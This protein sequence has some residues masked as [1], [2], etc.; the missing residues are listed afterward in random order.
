MTSSLDE[1]L[2]FS[3]SK[4]VFDVVERHDSEEFLYK[5][6]GFAGGPPADNRLARFPSTALLQFQLEAEQI[7]GKS[8]CEK[9]MTRNCMRDQLVLTQQRST[10]KDGQF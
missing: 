8:N 10:R 7:G 6:D 4:L 3:I 9:L 5:V 1:L 2:C